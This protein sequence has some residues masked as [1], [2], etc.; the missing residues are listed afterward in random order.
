MREYLKLFKENLK[1]SLLFLVFVVVYLLQAV[2]A[3]PDKNAIDKYHVSASTLHA[4]T[5][6]IAIPY[7]L[8]WIFGLVG[9][10]RLKSYVNV[11]GTSKDGSAW[12]QISQGILLL[13]LWLP[14][15]VLTSALAKAFYTA[16]PADTAWMVRLLNYGH[17]VLLFPAF[18]LLYVGSKK[19]VAV[20][21][22]QAY[23]LTQRQSAMFLIF[24]VLYVFIAL[25]DTTRQ[26][27]TNNS[28][29]A[30]YYLPDWLTVVTVLIPRLLIWFI[31]CAAVSNIMRYRRK[32]KGTIYREGLHN[33]AYGLGVVICG[34]VVLRVIQSLSAQIGG[35]SLGLLLLIIYALLAL[36]GTGYALVSKGSKRLLKIEES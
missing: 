1:I 9:Y 30:T 8:I 20:A 2:M 4:L 14:F 18:Y 33:I 35:A 5:L 7:V 27:A 11:L 24:S 36:L 21:K 15:T 12:R 6:T 3:A 10:L 17:I 34:I 31:G 23:G 32:V 16:H 26:M 29:V 13:V 25:N 22:V 19:L 28:M